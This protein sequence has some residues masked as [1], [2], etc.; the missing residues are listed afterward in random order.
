M[1][2]ADFEYGDSIHRCFRCGYCKFPVNWT[3]VN[4]CPPYARFRMESY[5]CGGRLW[6][7]RAWLNEQLDWTEHLAEILYSCTTCKNCVVKCPLRF[8]VDIVNMIVAARG[9]MVE[10]G[11]VPA[12]VKRFLENT[13]L[14]GNPYGESRAKRGQWAQ[15]T[16]VQ[17]YKGQEYL[18]YVGCTGSYDT[19]AQEAARTLAAVLT[20]AGVS[21]GILGSDEGCDGNEV[22][23][24]GE[25]GLFEMLAEN[26]T[27]QFKE[28]GV[29]RIVTLSPHAYN[30]M[31]NHYDQYGGNFEVFHYTQLLRQL[32]GEGRITQLKGLDA[33][34]TFHDPCFLGRWNDE[35]EAPR[36]LLR[37]IEGIEFV[38]MAK[39]KE[40]SLCCGGGAGNFQIDLL[41][42]SESR[43]ARRR[44]REAHQ[45]G[46]SI[47]AVA[48][49]KCLAMLSDAVKS[50]D[51]EGKLTVLDVS[52]IVAKACGIGA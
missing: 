38:E 32:L 7:T 14:M 12:A 16:E 44:V 3:D 11:K 19:R 47:L 17:E 48:C 29:R 22:R 42:G 18:Y 1:S 24:L 28:R 6:L 49:P 50:E 27:S 31:K 26:N 41:G 40:S 4:N 9:E 51:L 10:A 30:A 23:K 5:S 37:G 21:F 20:K 36:A 13:E 15:G 46:S 35:Y 33:K 43:P 34:I 52:E 2:I 25:A 39:S 8:N 45:T